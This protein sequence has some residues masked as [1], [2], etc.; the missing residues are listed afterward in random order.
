M[1]QNIRT[2]LFTF[3]TNWSPTSS[4]SISSFLLYGKWSNNWNTF[5]LFI[6]KKLKYT[7][8][9]YSTSVFHLSSLKQHI[10]F[11]FFKWA[12][13][14]K[15]NHWIQI[16]WCDQ[17]SEFPKLFWRLSGKNM[18]WLLDT[19]HCTIP[20]SVL[21][22]LSVHRTTNTLEQIPHTIRLENGTTDCKKLFCLWCDTYIDHFIVEP[23]RDESNSIWG[24]EEPQRCHRANNK[25]V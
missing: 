10:V 9:R 5:L 13:F 21:Q 8:N 3:A 15:S 6:T 7:W 18:C 11:F 19:K 2:T 1:Q 17:W 23:L 16:V 14:F 25:D 20:C 12:F 22:L 4:A 24:D